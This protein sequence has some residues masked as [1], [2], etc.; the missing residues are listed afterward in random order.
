MADPVPCPRCKRPNA[1]H[2]ITCL[3]CGTAMPAPVPRAAA[4]ESGALPANLDALVRE[5]LAGGNIGKLKN[6]MASVRA[7]PPAAPSPVVP[8]PPRAARASASP[9][10]PATPDPAK[11]LASRAAAAVPSVPEPAP[12]GPIVA[13]D[14]LSDA[15]QAVVSA[16][17]A[18]Q[19]AH[20]R[21]RPVHEALQAVRQALDYAQAIAPPVAAPRRPAAEAALPSIA[22]PLLVPLPDEPPV[23]VPVPP[24]RHRPAVELPRYR[25]HWML[26]IHGP[27]DAE[28]GP[29]LA[30]ALGV[31]GVT[32]R[33]SAVA[34]TPRVALRGNDPTPL[35]AAA[36]QVQR[37][38]IDAVVVGR[39]ELAGIAAPDVVLGCSGEGRFHVSATWPWSADPPAEHPPDT[40]TL[41]W[42][43]M[44]LAVPGEIGLRRYR[45]GRSLARGRRKE[46]V[47]RLGAERR[48]TVIDLHGPGRFFRLVAGLTDTVGLPGHD[49]R[50][51]LR[52]FRGLTDGLPELI[53][54]S[55]VEGTRLCSPGEAPTIPAG[56]DGS[57]PIEVSGWPTWEEHTRMCRLLA[58]LPG[59]DVPVERA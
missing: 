40:R 25:H 21:G 8:P 45:V 47:L 58:G 5:A 16:A 41:P 53:R 28:L 15:I 38:G 51:A 42:T 43:G 18:A 6:A 36:V 10:R 46:Q 1:A 23:P 3:Y 31:D 12:G 56:Y 9:A 13:P 54:G 44:T 55:R 49:P 32:A 19:S 33:F 57:E 11:R 20:A 35:R 52:A 30:K 22:A 2:R 34:R 17:R 50:S 59:D 27:G 37:L 7:Q 14:A 39:E 48:V 24:P 26:V 29:A 4:A